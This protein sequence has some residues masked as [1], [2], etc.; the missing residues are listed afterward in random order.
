VILGAID[1]LAVTSRAEPVIKRT[2]PE[3][4]GAIACNA[5]HFRITSY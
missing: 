4:S 5:S 2:I 1:S 3:K